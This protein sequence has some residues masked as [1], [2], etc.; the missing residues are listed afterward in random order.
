MAVETV[1][2]AHPVPRPGNPS[3]IPTAPTAPTAPTT[4][5]EI[6]YP[7]LQ[8]LTYTTQAELGLERGPGKTLA[9]PAPRER[10]GREPAGR[11]YGTYARPNGFNPT[12]T[13]VT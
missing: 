6:E 13:S 7:Y 3:G 5:T 12:V 2:A 1:E 11:V 9:P 10:R 8:N 4:T